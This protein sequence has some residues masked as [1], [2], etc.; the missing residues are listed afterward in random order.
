MIQMKKFISDE[1]KLEFNE[2]TQ[3]F[4]LRNG[5]DYIGFRF[6][7]TDSGKVIRNVRQQTKKKYKRKLKYFKKAYAAGDITLNEISM[8]INSYTHICF[9]GI[10]TACV[11]GCLI[12]LSFKGST[13]P[14]TISIRR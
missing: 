1:L 10:H 4:P 9:M 8:T 3:I 7:L 6:Y 12:I 14:P 11:R 5:V 13:P 2:K